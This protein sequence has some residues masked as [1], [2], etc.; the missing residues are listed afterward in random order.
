VSQ[1]GAGRLSRRLKRGAEL[2]AALM[3]AAMFGAFVIQVVTR[4]VLHDPAGW[5][6]EL[7]TLAY[8]WVVFFAAAFILGERE[9]IAFDMLYHAAP[10]AGR[11]ILAIAQSLILLLTFLVVLPGTFDYVTFMSRERTWILQIPFSLAFACFLV[12]VVMVILRAGLRVRRL[13]GRDWADELG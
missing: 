2:A 1:G 11:R 8:V 6:S 10:P 5:T 4:Y 7:A 12:F 13:L 9:H 3:F